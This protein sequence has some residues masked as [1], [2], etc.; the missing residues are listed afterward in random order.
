MAIKE[1][2]VKLSFIY[3][4]EDKEGGGLINIEYEEKGDKSIIKVQE[5]GKNGKLEEDCYSFDVQ[6]FVETVDFLREKGAIEGK[7]KEE[8]E[9]QSIIVES[10][11]GGIPL[12]QIDGK[13]D[14]IEKRKAEA[15][16]LEK[17]IRTSTAPPLMSLVSGETATQAPQEEE[18]P[19]STK[20]VVSK[21][22]EDTAP[23]K[24]QIKEM[25]RRGVIKSSVDE[26]STEESIIADQQMRSQLR[27]GDSEKSITRK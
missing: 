12:P 25:K 19:S 16:E 22:V 2:P 1:K 10:P 21:V 23:T 24:E 13:E 8:K 9:P 27:G 17:K 11:T 5:I 4:P 18:T 20:E 14:D 3:D 6:L 7:Q 26:N 15:I